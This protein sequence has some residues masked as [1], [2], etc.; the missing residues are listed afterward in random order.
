[1]TTQVRLNQVDIE[2]VGGLVAAVQADSA[3]A[4]TTWAAHVTWTGG[5]QSEAKVRQFP[6]AKSDEPP[7]LGG[8]DTA[9]NPVEQLL[10][11]LGNCL[12]VG[13]A[14]NATVAGIQLD[15]LTV[16]VKGDVDL[17]VFL[18]LAEGHAGFDGITA[19]VRIDSP[20]DRAD[21]EALHAKVIASSPVGHTLT[22]AVPVEVRLA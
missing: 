16:D 12:A 8:G 14:A 10:G 7:A 1:M 4:K 20:A 6:A 21:L 17:H 11:A 18:G 22:A 13:Y 2:A 5:F 19:T 9:A 15:R 3:K